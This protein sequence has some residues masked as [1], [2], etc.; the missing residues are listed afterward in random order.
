MIEV[1]VD[2]KPLLTVLRRVAAGAADATPLMRALVGDMHD[3][4]ETNFARE[5]RPKWLG[6][7]PASLIARAGPLTKAGQVSGARFEKRVRNA[8][9]LQHSGRLAAS[10]R[11]FYNSTSATVGTNVKYAAIHQFGGTTGPHVI[12]PKRKKA[13]A[14][15]GARH[16]FKKVDHPGSKIPA[17]PF[18]SLTAEDEARM[19][20]SAEQYLRSL[21]A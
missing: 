8:R 2:D 11:V 9:I 7:K 6:L 4:V 12:R 21:G 13:L 17:R 15:A 10:I 18:L 19:L 1:K 14:W 3:A 16:P 20:R 5:G